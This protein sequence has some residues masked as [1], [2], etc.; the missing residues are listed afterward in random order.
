MKTQNATFA[1]G[2]TISPP[3]ASKQ[4]P[5]ALQPICNREAFNCNRGL[6]VMTTVFCLFLV[7]G[8]A[9]C[10]EPALLASKLAEKV[11]ARAPLPETSTPT[12][13]GIAAVP[14]PGGALITADA[15]Q[16]ADSVKQ[17]G[18]WQTI[19][20]IPASYPKTTTALTVLAAVAPVLANNPKLLGLEKKEKTFSAPSG[21]SHAVTDNSVQVNVSGNNGSTI[22]VVLQSPTITKEEK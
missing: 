14:L 3:A 20:N 21:S 16:V 1:P 4:A 15:G 2:S 19:K 13:A 7:S 6:K 12:P 17:V 10:Q 8:Q 9:F 22:T 18:W 5:S 11:V